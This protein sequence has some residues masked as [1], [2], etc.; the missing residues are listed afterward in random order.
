MFLD[1]SI[2]TIEG[3][4]KY[5][6]QILQSEHVKQAELSQLGDYLL[7]SKD[8]N[9]TKKE[10]KEDYPVLTTNRECTINKRQ[11]SYEGL[12]EKLENGENGIYNLISDNHSQILDPKEPISQEDIDTIP[13]LADC[14]TVIK[15]L[16]KQY[17][18]ASNYR[19]KQLKTAL[20]NTWKQAY[21]IKGSHKGVAVKS[22]IRTLAGIEIPEKVCFTEDMIPYSDSPLS[23]LNPKHISFLLKYYQILKQESWDMPYSD[24]KWHLIDLE[25][26]TEKAL[27]QK[28]PILWDVLI[29]K[30][31][32][33][34]NKQIQEKVLNHHGEYH[35][36]QYYS[37]V[38]KQRIPKL[39]AEQ[40]RKKYLFC[41]YWNRPAAASWKKCSKC[42]QVKI[43]H[44]L[45][46]NK[47]S[48]KSG[49]YSQCKECRSQKNR[50]C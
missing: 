29:W 43:G 40:A 31:D 49:W 39:I 47:N 27:K 45:F 19:K 44:S 35:T 37:T 9:Q 28:Y 32:G 20:I 1:Y 26:F 12:A 7:F 2:S 17:E 41:F 15:S 48:N 38:W 33:L 3:R 23:L 42:G 11:L 21:L 34:T 50:R 13:G 4:K 36:E 5:V 16:Q 24:M 8:K 14:M 6:E 30:I 22:K 46:F 25:N 10:K 18:T